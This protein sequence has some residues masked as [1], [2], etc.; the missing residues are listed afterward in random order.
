MP[1]RMSMRR[2]SGAGAVQLPLMSMDKAL[3]ELRWAR[4][5]G[6]CAVFMRGQPGA[7]LWIGLVSI[8]ALE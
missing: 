7:V 2:K 1:T 5:N 4:G 8:A 6:A 3:D